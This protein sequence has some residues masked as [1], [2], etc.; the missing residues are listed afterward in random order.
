M[1]DDLFVSSSSNIFQH[2]PTSSIIFHHLPTSPT[3]FQHLP[4]SSNLHF[5]CIIVKVSLFRQ[6]ITCSHAAMYVAS[7][8]ALQKLQKEKCSVRLPGTDNHCHGDVQPAVEDSW[9]CS[10]KM[11]KNILTFK[12]RPAQDFGQT[13]CWVRPTLESECTECTERGISKDW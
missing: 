12:L 10:Q 6:E 8:A 1:V 2:F 9:S 13:R 3:I 4:R 5:C 7:V 11:Q